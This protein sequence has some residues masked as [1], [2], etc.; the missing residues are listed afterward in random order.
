MHVAS[1]SKNTKLNILVSER[2]ISKPVWPSSI[3]VI[4]RLVSL[5]KICFIFCTILVGYILNIFSVVVDIKY[6]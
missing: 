3:E 1:V 6:L 2:R 5:L 4:N